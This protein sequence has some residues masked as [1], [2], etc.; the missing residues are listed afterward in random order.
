ML[1]ACPRLFV[2]II[3]LAR[4]W[5]AELKGLKEALSDTSPVSAKADPS[6]QVAHQDPTPS[7]GVGEDV[8]TGARDV[9][10]E[11]SEMGTVASVDT[12]VD[13]EAPD[14]TDSDSDGSG[15]DGEGGIG[16][17][18]AH[19]TDVLADAAYMEMLGNATGIAAAY[20]GVEAVDGASSRAFKRHRRRRHRKVTLK[21]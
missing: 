12:D 8:V 6:A 7:A 16:S 9:T 19:L 18:V 1:R 3:R 15:A 4:G 5:E 10:L 21:P 14:S 17:H 20:G 11:H 13:T 2:T